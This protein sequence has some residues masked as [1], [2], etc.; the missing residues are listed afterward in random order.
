MDKIPGMISLIIAL[1][2]LASMLLQF[3]PRAM[4]IIAILALVVLAAYQFAW[5]ARQPK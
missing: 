5:S 2:L 1:F 3:D 4:G